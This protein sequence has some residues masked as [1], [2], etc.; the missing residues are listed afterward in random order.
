MGLA[1]ELTEL[2]LKLV[3]AELL[4]VAEFVAELTLARTELVSN[5]SGAGVEARCGRVGAGTGGGAGVGSG[6]GACGCG[7]TLGAGTRPITYVGVIQLL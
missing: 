7:A 2:V 3:A 4:L 5:G 1:L 6:A